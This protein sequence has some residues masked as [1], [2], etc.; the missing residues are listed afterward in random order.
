MN[1]KRKNRRAHKSSGNKKELTA[2]P[3]SVGIKDAKGN[4]LIEF[5]PDTWMRMYLNRE[6]KK[7]CD[8]FLRILKYMDGKLRKK[9]TS[10]KRL[11]FDSFVENFLFFF[12]KPQFAIPKEHF[13]RFLNAKKV[14]IPIVFLSD[15]KNTD[16]WVA[17]LSK[18]IENY[19]KILIL[20]SPRNSIMLDTSKL[21]ETANDLASTWW[22]N[23]WITAPGFSSK[24]VHRKMLT[25]LQDFDDRYVLFSLVALKGYFQSTYLD[26]VHEKT[27]KTKLNNLIQRTLSHVKIINQPH[28][29]KVAIVTGKWYQCAVYKSLS[30]Y[31]ASL[32]PDY[33][34]TLIHLG[35]PIKSL[36]TSMFEKVISIKMT[37][38]NMDLA[39]IQSNEFSVVYYPDIG[40]NVESILLSNIRLAPIQIMGY[41]HPVSTHGSKIDYFIGGQNVEDIEEAQNNY[42]ERLVLIPGI[43][44]HPVYPDCDIVKAHGTKKVLTINCAWTATKVNYPMLETLKEILD[45]SNKPVLFRFFPNG[46]LDRYDSFIPF[47]LDIEAVLGELHSHVVRNMRYQ[48]YLSIMEMGNISIDSYPFGGYNTIMDSLYLGIPIVTWKGSKACNRIAS[49]TLENIGLSE[50]VATNRN[51]YIEKTIRLI[52]DDSYREQMIQKI[53]SIDLK[54][55]I[56]QSEYPEYFK[57]AVDYLIENHDRLKTEKSKTPIFIKLN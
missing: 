53:R 34:L 45:K 52:D 10:E 12:C 22:A 1:K 16:P 44:A 31:V 39:K 49:A 13:F 20:Y 51:E 38:D 55:S 25:H 47:V 50:L 36:H 32:R 18:K 42:S 41:G 23:C 11:F 19:L 33:D 27:Y 15:F 14:L 7:L 3:N 4:T 2:S 26:P 56:T 9:P 57:K 5:T 6:Y 29:N 37:D 30:P 40:M 21:F 54:E 46:K 35:K 17:M 8:E 28:K 24:T 43:G 48:K